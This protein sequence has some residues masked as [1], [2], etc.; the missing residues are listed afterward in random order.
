MRGLR[1]LERLERRRESLLDIGS[2]ERNGIGREFIE[3]KFKAGAVGGQRTLQKAL[4]RKSDEPEPVAR[5]EFDKFL[6]EPFRVRETRR[7]NVL[8]EHAPGD[9]EDKEQVASLSVEFLDLYAPGGSCRRDDETEHGE[10]EQDKTE[11][12][13]AF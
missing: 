4:P 11:N 1:R 8:C 7:L 6:H 5:I 9:V 13:S 10:A 2:P 3:R 12:T